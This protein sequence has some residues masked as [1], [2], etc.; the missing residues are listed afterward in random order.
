[1][2]EFR[3]RF[4][5][6]HFKFFEPI[7]DNSGYYQPSILLIVG[8]ADV[9]WRV[10][11]TCRT[12]AF[13]IGL[14]VMLLKFPLRDTRKTEFPFLSGSSTRARSRFRCS[15]SRSLAG[16]RRRGR[17]H[18][19][20]PGIPSYDRRVVHR[21]FEVRFTATRMAK[22]Y[23]GTYRRMLKARKSIAKPRQLDLNCG[24]RLT[25]ISS[26]K[27]IP[28]LCEAGVDPEIPTEERHIY[29]PKS[30]QSQVGVCGTH[31]Q[32]HGLYW[33]IIWI[34]CNVKAEFGAHGEH[35]GILRQNLD[36]HGLEVLAP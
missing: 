25:S 20:T 23:V 26:E 29:Q 13:L 22:D 15:P 18:R 14:H 32:C 9:P 11:V 24:K 6:R 7:E 10:M 36:S 12:E 35:G 21:L 17:R 19:G 33:G 31:W 1:V 8:G 5:V 30:R 28:A 4:G 27:P 34:I 3:A 16:C 2:A